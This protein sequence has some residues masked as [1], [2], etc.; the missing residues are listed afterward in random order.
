MLGIVKKSDF[1]TEPYEEWFLP[2]YREYQ[3]DV[4]ILKEIGNKLNAFEIESF[5]GS[6]C[7]DSK[8]ELPR[9]I[10]ILESLDFPAANHKIFALDEDKKSSEGFENGKDIK[11]VPVF[12]LYSNRKE[13]GRIVEYPATD[14]LEKDLLSIVNGQPL[15]PNYSEN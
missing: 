14:S 11:R 13:S 7:G 4:A 1:L 6:W 2:E 9:F 5:I 10:K 15:T 8:R 12:I 3:P